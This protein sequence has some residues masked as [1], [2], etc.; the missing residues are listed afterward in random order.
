MGKFKGIFV[1][2]L[3]TVVNPWHM[4]HRPYDSCTVHVSVCLCVCYLSIPHLRVQSVV[5]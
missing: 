1:P 5:L 2:G 3:I 4:R